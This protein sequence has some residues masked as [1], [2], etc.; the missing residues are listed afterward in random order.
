MFIEK[1]IIVSFALSVRYV[2]QKRYKDI[3][4]TERKRLRTLGAINI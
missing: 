2:Q 1:R 4:R 3:A